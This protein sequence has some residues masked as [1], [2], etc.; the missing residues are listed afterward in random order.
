MADGDED[1][2]EVEP[3]NPAQEKQ[4]KAVLIQKQLE[5]YK[6]SVGINPET[7]LVAFV[8][9]MEPDKDKALNYQKKADQAD[10]DA[11]AL[12]AKACLKNVQTI[13]DELKAMEG[14]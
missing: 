13:L 4:Q 1:L 8:D 14:M 9:T 3:F 11:A 12:G 10:I 5:S 6:N 2:P 7:V